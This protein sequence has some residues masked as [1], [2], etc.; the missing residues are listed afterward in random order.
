MLDEKDWQAAEAH[1]TITE[2]EQ[3]RRLKMI[4]DVLEAP[5]QE[6]DDSDKMSILLA[7]LAVYEKRAGNSIKVIMER[8]G[9]LVATCPTRYFEEILKQ[10]SKTDGQN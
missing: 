3:N 4:Y 5:F 9:F 6:W 2:P 8:V 1:I 10:P 7:L